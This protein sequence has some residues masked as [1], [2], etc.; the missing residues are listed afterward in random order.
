[1]RPLY[2]IGIRAWVTQVL[3]PLGSNDVIYANEGKPR[4]IPPYATVQTFSDTMFGLPERETVYDSDLDQIENLIKTTNNG[5][6][7]VSIFGDGHNEAARTLVASTWRQSTINLIKPYGLAVYGP[8]VTI[9]ATDSD[10][11][12]ENRSIVSIT[13]SWAYVDSEITNDWIESVI[14]TGEIIP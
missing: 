3:I 2:E 1:M 5:T 14:L 9:L 4:P 7:S 8:T 12:T 13:Y 6:G 10:G 11:V